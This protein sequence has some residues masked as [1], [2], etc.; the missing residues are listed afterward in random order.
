[1]TDISIHGSGFYQIVGESEPGRAFMVEQVDHADRYGVAFCDSG[2]MTQA[3]ADGAVA[4]GL[5]VEVNGRLYLP[6]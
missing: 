2:P 5:R 4:E 1:M 3:I 6:D